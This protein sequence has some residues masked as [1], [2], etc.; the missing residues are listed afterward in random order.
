MASGEDLQTINSYL[1][2]RTYYVDEVVKQEK[3]ILSEGTDL[4]KLKLV[5]QYKNQQDKVKKITIPLTVSKEYSNNKLFGG[6]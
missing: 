4:N 2:N 6:V 3:N 1:L 5:I